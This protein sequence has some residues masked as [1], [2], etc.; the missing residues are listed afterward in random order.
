MIPSHGRG[1]AYLSDGVALAQRDS[2]S[3]YLPAVL[4][5]C[6]QPQTVKGSVKLLVV[7]YWAKNSNTRHPNDR[8]L[9]YQRSVTARACARPVRGIII[10]RFFSKCDVCCSAVLAWLGVAQPHTA[11]GPFTSIRTTYYFLLTRFYS[12]WGR[13]KQ[14]LEGRKHNYALRDTKPH[15]IGCA[16]HSILVFDN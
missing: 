15:C 16:Y 3:L 8:C 5:N 7:Q 1:Y 6:A 9:L 2:P 14:L 4:A 12:T 10:A 11:N 13:E